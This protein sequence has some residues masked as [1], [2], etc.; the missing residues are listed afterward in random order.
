MGDVPEPLLVWNDPPGRL[1]RNHERY[2]PE[3]F[4]RVK[5]EYLSRWL[6]RCNPRHPRV[7]VFG[8]GRVTR[9]RVE[10]LTAFGVEV[11]AYVD[12]DPRKVGRKHDGV[13]VIGVDEVRPAGRDFALA[14]VGKRGARDLIR[15][16]LAKLGYR[17]GRDWLPVA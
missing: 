16:W 7:V 5:S 15:S 1:S 6:A 13:P 10:M 2:S 11:V 14:Y 4:Y 8:S 17:L 12:I 9:R 3:A